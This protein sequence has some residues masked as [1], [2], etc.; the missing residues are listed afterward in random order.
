[1]LIV[2]VLINV[3]CENCGNYGSYCAD[4]EHD[5]KVKARFS[6]WHIDGKVKCGKCRAYEAVPAPPPKPEYTNTCL[7]CAGSDEHHH[8]CERRFER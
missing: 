3:K 2:T 6:G 7:A 1:M 5:A 8:T 4:T